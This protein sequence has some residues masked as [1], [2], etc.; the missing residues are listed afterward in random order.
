MFIGRVG[1]VSF[2]FMLGGK[3]KKE[4]FHYPKERVTIG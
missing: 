1:I 4:N 2:M 3:E